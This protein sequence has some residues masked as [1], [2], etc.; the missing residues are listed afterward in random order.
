M[1]HTV[2]F[3]NPQG[4]KLAGTLHEPA[5][6]A[7]KGV[8]IGHCFTCSRHTRVLRRVAVNLSEAGFATLRFDFS[9]NGQSQV[10]LPIQGIQSTFWK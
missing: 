4:E 9:G 5:T 6:P 1:E 2:H 8:V 7:D 10:V 3:E